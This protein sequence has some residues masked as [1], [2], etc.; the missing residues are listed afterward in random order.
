PRR[1]R[2]SPLVR[3]LP[4]PAAGAARRGDRPATCRD[5]GR[6]ARGMAAPQRRARAARPAGRPA[7]ARPG[8]G[9][10]PDMSPRL[11]AMLLVAI[12]GV[13][14]TGVPPPAA[15]HARWASYS[16]WD[17]TGDGGVVTAR[18][19]ALEAT[20]LPWPPGDIA[21]LGDY[22]STHL[23]LVAGEAPCPVSS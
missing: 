17:L 11:A 12:V 21:R 1:D 16:T 2:P 8:R 22:L 3:R 15:A 20:R 18:L 7:L 10:G 13:G 23:R 19:A 14:G 9:G 6:G 4:R 5:R